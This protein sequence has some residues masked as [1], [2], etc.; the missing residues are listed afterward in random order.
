MKINP[1]FGTLSLNK[2][3]AR[4]F[5]DTQFIYLPFKKPEENES[6][7]NA[8]KMHELV[9][10]Y[11]SLSTPFGLH[12]SI[13][14]TLRTIN[15][16][17]DLKNTTKYMTHKINMPIKQWITDWI[18]NRT[19]I[20]DMF[21][22]VR[23]IDSSIS[24]FD[25]SSYQLDKSEID[26][27]Y[28]K[29]QNTYRDFFP[30]Q[31]YLISEPEQSWLYPCPQCYTDNYS[32]LEGHAL[33]WENHYKKLETFDKK[34]KD[35][36]NQIEMISKQ[37]R[38]YFFSGSSVYTRSYEIANEYLDDNTLL[39]FPFMCDLALFGE[40]PHIKGWPPKKNY[41]R[42]G[43]GG[44]IS[45]QKVNPGSRF[46][47]IFFFF[48][49]KG[50]HVY[51]YINLFKQKN[52]K[53]LHAIVDEICDYYKWKHPYDIINEEIS[54]V[55]ILLDT[56]LTDSDEIKKDYFDLINLLKLAKEILLMRKEN[57]FILS[58]PQNFPE[59]TFPVI[60]YIDGPQLS[61]SE[62]QTAISCLID[63]VLCK[64]LY[65]YFEHSEKKIEEMQRKYVCPAKIE[66]ALS[67]LCDKINCDGI[68]ENCAIG[69]HLKNEW[70][71]ATNFIEN[72]E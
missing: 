5:L 48:Q 4:Y 9:H 39:L 61:S 41:G 70:G 13:L 16:K 32:I 2:F 8:A 49:N 19:P 53:E 23:I 68:E 55:D 12:L 62:N 6:W 17:T 35:F 1:N 10:L 7:Q 3:G 64:I 72:M 20:T 58:F 52:I 44:S 54:M 18:Y 29:L 42:C 59:T 60:F 36:L 14:N 57:L 34:N 33:Y 38:D 25:P 65:P 51:K 24:A 63:S 56:I 47:D 28:N 46:E 66:P 67:F 22:K 31:D 37:D 40:V 15:I 50:H 26:T 21:Y 27:N 30:F 45:F 43:K 71:L 11:Q 69:Q